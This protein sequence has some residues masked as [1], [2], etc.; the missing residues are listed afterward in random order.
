MHYLGIATTR[1]AS[2]V[3]SDEPVWRD[4]FYDGHPT[5][6]KGKSFYFILDIVLFSR[7]HSPNV[8]TRNH[9]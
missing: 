1:A 7:Q 4:Q 2:I 9:K 8:C 3:M 5:T 6:E